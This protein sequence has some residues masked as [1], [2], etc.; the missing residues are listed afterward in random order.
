[1]ILPLGKIVV[2]TPGTPVSL[3]AAL[4]AALGASPSVIRRL[5]LVCLG[6]NAGKI[7]I[8]TIALNKTTLAGCIV[9]DG[10]A[11]GQSLNLYDETRQGSAHNFY[12]YVAE[13]GTILDLNRLYVDADNA[14]DGIGGY[15][16]Y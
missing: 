11:A 12:G 8:G 6:A 9:G 10:L 7:Y 14:N 16:I 13:R 2:P 15:A 1:M 4:A 3:G 5:N